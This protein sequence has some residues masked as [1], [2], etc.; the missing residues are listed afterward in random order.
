MLALFASESRELAISNEIISVGGGGRQ[1]LK[2]ARMLSFE[3]RSDMVIVLLLAALLSL[4]LHD[5]REGW[6]S[7]VE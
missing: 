7:V 4:C 6:L 2:S 1:I 5:N 3:I